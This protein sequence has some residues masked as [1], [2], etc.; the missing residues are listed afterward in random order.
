MSY[1]AR[2]NAR[3]ES[4]SGISRVWADFNMEIEIILSDRN[5]GRLLDRPMYD[6]AISDCRKIVEWLENQPKTR[7]NQDALEIKTNQL[8]ELRKALIRP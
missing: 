2:L 6:A 8:A 5:M 1:L 7:D 4:Y 3:R